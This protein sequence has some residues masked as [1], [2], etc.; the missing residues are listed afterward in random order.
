MNK[1]QNIDNNIVADIAARIERL[2][3]LEPTWLGQSILQ[4]P[5]KRAIFGD[6]KNRVGEDHST[7]HDWIVVP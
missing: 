5:P 3:M 7:T 2:S 4:Q 1:R 6:E